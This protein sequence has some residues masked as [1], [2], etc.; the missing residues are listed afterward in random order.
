MRA[1]VTGGAGFLGSHLCERLLGDGYEVVCIDNFL[2]GR[3]DNVEHLLADPRF[4]LVNRDVNDFIYVSG[5][6]D[7]VLHFASPASPIDY[8]ELPIETLKVGSL[9]TFHALGLAREKNARFLLASTSESYGDP[10]VN[11]Q[12]ESYWGNV[13]PVGPRSVYDEAKRFAEALTMAYRRKHGVDTAIVRIFNTYGPRMRVDDGRAIP[14]FVSQALRGEPITVAGDGSQTRSIC[15]VD[16][17]IEGILRLLHSDLPGPV[18]IGNP[19]EM[20]ILDTAMLVRDLCGSSAPITFVP[21]PQDD[22]SVRQPDIT[23]ARTQLGWEPR[24]ALHEGLTRTISWFAGQLTD[25]PQV[26]A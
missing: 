25:S 16:D 15:Y 23:I 26:V 19:H 6:V 8:H 10:L 21:R 4:R 17:L 24:T 22:P 9:G 1:I 2:T 11:P 13:N 3:P 7:V 18:N 20:S 12:P 14:A 5:P